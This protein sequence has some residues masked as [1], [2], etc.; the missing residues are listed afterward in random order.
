MS[1]LRA[2]TYK[3]SLCKYC[4][5]FVGKS[6]IFPK[7]TVYQHFGKAI[8]DEILRGNFDHRFPHPEDG[9][10][11][12]EPESFDE[13]RKRTFFRYKTDEEIEELFQITINK[14][15]EI[16]NQTTT[17]EGHLPPEWFMYDD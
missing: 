7:C 8:P 6:I 5:Y 4:R 3:R 15:S 17:N 1:L 10:I 14:L 12:F 13:L 16:K 2:I 9:G 11:Q